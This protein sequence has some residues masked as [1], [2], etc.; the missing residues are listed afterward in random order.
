MKNKYPRY[1]LLLL[2]L[3]L[4][5]HQSIAQASEEYTWK[6]VQIQGGGFVTGLVY[7]TTEKDLVYARTDVGGAYRWNGETKYWIPLT[8]HLGRDEQDFTGVLSLATD[9]SDPN[10]VYLATGLYT[11]SWAG[12][13]AILAS[14]DKGNTWTKT[15]LPIKLGG[16]EDG[17]SAGERLQ[18]DPNLG[19]TLYLGS[20]T[21]GLW[22]STDYGVTWDKVNSFPVSDSPIGSGGI[23]FV[24]F[25]KPSGAT[26]SATPTMYVGILQAMPNLYKSTDG[27]STW[28]AVADAPTDNMPHQAALAADGTLYLTYSNGP[29]PNNITSGAVWKLNTVSG[30]W[31]N[32]NPPAGQGGYAGLSLDPQKSATLIVSTMDRWWPHD[33][34]FYSSNGGETW[35]ALLSSATF[36]HSLA[37]YAATSSPHWIGDVEIDPFD[38][39]NAW[40]TT[41]YG[42][43]NSNNLSAAANDGSTNWIFQNRG[44]EETV[45]LQLISPPSGAPLV[46]ALGDID[47][48]RHDNLDVSPAAGRLSPRFGTNTSID[49]AEDKP[50]FMARTHYNADSKY[51]A[52]STDGGSTWAA[53]ASSP[54]GTTGGGAIAVSADGTSLVWAPGGTSG[55]YYSRNKGASWS[56]ATGIATG[57]LKPVADRVNAGKFYVYDAGAGRVLV[58][59]NGGASFATA[60]TGLPAVPGW[61]LWAANLEAVFGAEGELWLTNPN[62]GLYRS[63]NLGTGF[64]KQANVQEAVKVGLGK[65]A[66]GKTYPAIFIAGTVA[67]ERGFFRSDDAGAIWVR[68]ND[69]QHQFGGVNDITGDPRVF[70]R[71]YIATA[72]RG[73]VYGDVLGVVNGI[74]DEQ[75]IDFSYFPN[76]FV[77]TLQLQADAPFTYSITNMMGAKAAEGRCSGKCA[78]GAGLQPGIY[79]LTIK[80]SNKVQSVKI[81][82]Y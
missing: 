47:G 12:T 25:D 2:V 76:P 75:K 24:L 63:S 74:E 59:T 39:D 72:G 17:R 8:D 9:P 28:Q 49:F 48:F 52:Y 20:S 62:G 64:V 56:S 23:S 31:T 4:V 30:Q 82:K 80:Q 36:D 27:G 40:F 1:F 21:D 73:I 35:Q 3:S 38:S 54:A 51:G 53:F 71:V 55:I 60:A 7:N 58:S 10:R 41:G 69:A 29:G 19:S 65:A 67:N 6:N 14:A 44:L 33:E 32:I 43:Y 50:E 5:H 68:I 42:V 57:G 13:G 22:K 45:P 46:S 77:T 34:L 26:G 66:A 78:V 70:G 11:Q 37:P 16:N 18:V 81:M 79:I 15:N 61:Q